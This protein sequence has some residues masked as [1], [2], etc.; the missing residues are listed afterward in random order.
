MRKIKF[1]K[2]KSD[3]EYNYEKKQAKISISFWTNKKSNQSLT[4][5]EENNYLT[6]VK[7]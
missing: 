3:A 1:S 2:P 7:M 5:E 6:K 4:G